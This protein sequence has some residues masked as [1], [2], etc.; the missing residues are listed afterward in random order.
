M[1]SKKTQTSIAQPNFLEKPS[2][3]L[4]SFI[5]IGITLAVYLSSI[6]NGF[7]NWDDD[8]YITQNTS[9]QSVD[10]KKLFSSYEQGNYHPLT[11]LSYSLEYQFFKL[12][13]KPYHATNILLHTLN[14]LLVL[15]FIWLLCKQKWVAFITAI[16]FAIH[17][18]HVESVAWI[19]ERKDVLYTFF[20]L[21]ALCTY[22]VYLQKQSNKSAYYIVTLLLFVLAILSKGMAIS[23]SVMLFVIDYF[24]DRKVTTK[25]FL[26]KLPFLL[27]ALVFGAIAIMAQKSG[28]AIDDVAEYN[29]FERILFSSYALLTYLWK[30]ILPIGLSCFYRYPAEATYLP[31]IFYIAPVIV[32]VIIYLIYKYKNTNR[33]LVFAFAFFFISIAMVIQVLPVGAAIVAERYT[34][35]SYI[36]LFFFI[37]RIGNNYIEINPKQFNVLIGLAFI[38]IAVYSIMSYQRTKVWKNSITL[39]TD[40]IE[41]D[42]SFPLAFNSRGDA[43]F[44][45][46]NYVKAIPDFTSSIQLNYRTPDVYYKR[47]LARFRTQ[48]YAAAVTDYDTVIILDNKFPDIYYSRGLANSNVGNYEQAIADYSLE[49]KNNPNYAKVY[50]DRGVAYD[51]AG[52]LNDALSDYTQAIAHDSTSVKAY[53]N[54][55]NVYFKQSDFVNALKD[56]NTVIRKDSTYADA[57]NNRGSV[58]GNLGKLNEAINDYTK[59]IVLNPKLKGAYANRARVYEMTKEF[60]KAKK[61]FEKIK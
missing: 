54:R 33:D 43:Y 23:F 34:Y 56:Y 61:D 38:V 35:I 48:Q 11:M 22:I 36:G 1:T 30:L 44:V 17:P 60:E 3:G 45:S 2:L 20:Y 52:K 59:A 4:L 41:K 31:F 46:E 12:N 13:P 6:N 39:W 24:F 9:I 55:A 25:T 37:G 51:N 32:F 47:G 10:F 14:S 15:L 40:A 58:Y 8:K 19:S 5:V 27:L 53:F 21:S 29:F 16:L 57:Y 7:T 28:N 49:L 42:D 50:N 18:M 26:E